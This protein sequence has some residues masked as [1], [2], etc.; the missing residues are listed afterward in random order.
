M[1]T[2][3]REIENTVVKK[4]KMGPK[5]QLIFIMADYNAGDMADLIQMT[6]FGKLFENIDDSLAEFNEWLGNEDK[7]GY[8]DGLDTIGDTLEDYT[9]YINNWSEYSIVFKKITH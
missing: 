9:K 2:H 8:F 1:A 6:F 5:S 4:Q 7:D 3:K